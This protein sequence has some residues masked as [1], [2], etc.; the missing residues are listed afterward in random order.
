LSNHIADLS[1]GRTARMAGFGYLIIFI[2]GIFAN[3]FVLQNLIVPG[4]AAATVGNILADQGLFRLGI[5]S[6]IIMV[7]FDLLLAWLLYLLLKPVNQDVSLFAAWFRLVNGAIFGFALYHLLSVLQLV[8]GADYLKVFAPGQLHAQVMLSLA[9]FNHTWL[10]GLI[11]FGFH[12]LLLGFLIIK[13][14]YIPQ[15][16][17]VLLIIAAFGYLIDSFANFLLSNYAEYQT[18]FMLIVVVPGIIGELSFTIWLIWKGGSISDIK[19]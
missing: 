16:L 9:A 2:S 10:I 5:L 19:S 17:G 8:S 7:I 13:S 12:L 18:I 11:F 15:I 1:P 4:D 3:F 6:F 14:G